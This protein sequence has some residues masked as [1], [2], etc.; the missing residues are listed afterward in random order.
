MQ[1]QRF[2]EDRAELEAHFA[3]R[4]QVY[5][6]LGQPLE[7]AQASAREKFGNPERYLQQLRLR[8][9]LLR[10]LQALGQGAWTSLKY[11][12]LSCFFA[13]VGWFVLSKT[14]EKL[15]FA[16]IILWT[17]GL[18]M[19]QVAG[20][21]DRERPKYRHLRV[22]GAVL[23]AGIAGVISS[24]FSMPTERQLFFLHWQWV[25]FVLLIF[26]AYF[27]PFRE[28]KNAKAKVP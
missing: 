27:R 16:D 19:L 3:E 5:V 8:R 18:S 24:L 4:V 10:P 2:D 26:V 22:F 7:Q 1:N 15:P 23:I 11:I 17:T 21:V 13:C 25:Y 12:P 6:D 20:I 9:Y 28:S 14:G